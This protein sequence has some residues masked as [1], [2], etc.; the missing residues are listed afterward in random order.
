MAGTSRAAG[1]K[2]LRICSYLLRKRFMI[3][4]VKSWLL[5]ILIN[6]RAGAVHHQI[7]R[8]LILIAIKYF[9]SRSLHWYYD[10]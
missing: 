1:G 4:F 2:R 8:D 9:D 7:G 6:Y 5:G 3:P 10:T